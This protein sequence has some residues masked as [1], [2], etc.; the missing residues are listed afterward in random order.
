MILGAG[1]S[2][3]IWNGATPKKDGRFRPP[4]AREL[5]STGEIDVFWHVL[6]EYPGARTLANLIQPAVA[7]G[8]SVEDPLCHTS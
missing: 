8:Q 3:D 7:A 4:L 1:A 6:N 5:F 2:F